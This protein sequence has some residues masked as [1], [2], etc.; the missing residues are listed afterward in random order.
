VKAGA[1]YHNAR[2]A[3]MEARMSGYSGLPESV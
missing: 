3:I 1:N 2:L